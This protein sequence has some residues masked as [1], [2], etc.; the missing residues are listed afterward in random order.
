VLL[1]V[2]SKYFLGKYGSASPL[3]K[4]AGMPMVVMALEGLHFAVVMVMPSATVNMCLPAFQRYNLFP[5][6]YDS[7]CR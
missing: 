1:F 4:L 5:F 7:L 2:L 6:S 3:D